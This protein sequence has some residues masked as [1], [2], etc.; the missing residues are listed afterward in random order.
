MA[1]A[2]LAANLHEA[3]F[4]EHAEMSTRRRPAV[5]EPRREIARRKLVAEVAQEEED[6]PPG[7]VRE[8]REDD[9]DLFER[10]WATQRE[11]SLLAST[12]AIST[13]AKC[14]R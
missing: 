1:A 11:T 9:G 2:P 13:L 5:L 3:R 4:L 6:V 7:L 8:G 12:L 10:G 14:G